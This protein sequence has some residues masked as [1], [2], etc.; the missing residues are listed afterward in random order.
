MRSSTAAATAL[1]A[2]LL[3]F[4]ATPAMAQPGIPTTEPPNAPTNLRI[5]RDTEG[6]I[7]FFRWDT[8]TGSDEPLTYY[9]WMDSEPQFFGPGAVENTSGLFVEAD[10]TPVCDGCQYAPEQTITV[11]V[12]A[13]RG[14][15]E[16]PPSNRLTLACCP[17]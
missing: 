2:C 7:Q 11:W 4:G 3:L 6:F 10:L 9:L 1:F 13:R 15:Q 5:E 17:F 12:V 8:P 14:I 16:S